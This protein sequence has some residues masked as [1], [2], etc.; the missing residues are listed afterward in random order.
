[1]TILDK[2]WSLRY[3]FEK[4]YH[5]IIFPAKFILIWQNASEEKIFKSYWI[6]KAYVAY[7]SE[8]KTLKYILYWW[9]S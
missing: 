7:L 4:G 8:L 2:D 5:P 6:K 1:V 3:N 9:P